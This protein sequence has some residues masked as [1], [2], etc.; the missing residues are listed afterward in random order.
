[1]YVII[2]RRIDEIK[3][4]EG[5]KKLHQVSAEE[6]LVAIGYERKYGKYR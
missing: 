4:S 6:G 5:W 2:S 1:M 3:V